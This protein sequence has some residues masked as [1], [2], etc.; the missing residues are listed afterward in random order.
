MLFIKIHAELLHERVVL[1]DPTNKEQV[2]TFNPLEITKGETATSIASELTEAFKKI[3]GDSWGA[4]M[5]DL[6]KN[7]LIALIQ[8]NLTLAE[9]PL[10]L[11]NTEV[12]R[13]ILEKVE[14]EGCRQYFQER[15][16]SLRRSRT[17]DERNGIHP[18]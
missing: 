14:H 3:W 7:T 5:E 16:N 17:Q 10:F 1:I 18:Q 15:F 2:V 4:R 9:L 6:L 8:N 12:R 13:K 11:T